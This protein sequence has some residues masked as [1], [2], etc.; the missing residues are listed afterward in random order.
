MSKKVAVAKFVIPLVRSTKAKEV[1]QN[2]W[3]WHW[4]RLGPDSF[5]FKS[6]ITAYQFSANHAL[7]SNHLCLAIPP[8]AKSPTK[9]SADSPEPN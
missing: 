5:L 7:K 1:E 3:R 9:P 8:T 6:Y 4:Q 2:F